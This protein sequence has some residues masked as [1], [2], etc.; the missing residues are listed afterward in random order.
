MLDMWQ[1]MKVEL[2]LYKWFL[3]FLLDLPTREQVK[4]CYLSTQWYK[5]HCWQ[6]VLILTQMEI[7]SQNHDLLNLKIRI[8]EWPSAITQYSDSQQMETYSHVKHLPQCKWLSCYI[9]VTPSP[10]GWPVWLRG[11]PSL[12][13]LLRFP[14][15]GL[16][17]LNPCPLGWKLGDTPLLP[18]LPAL[19][20]E[21]GSCNQNIYIIIGT[22]TMFKTHYSLYWLANT[23]FTTTK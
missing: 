15:S 2:K 5:Y 16:L 1:R 10:A 11:V 14:S 8:I 9:P 17:A 21:F 22:A 6:N 3:V 18:E 12:E 23:I 4:K 20:L 19:G 7:T 13:Q